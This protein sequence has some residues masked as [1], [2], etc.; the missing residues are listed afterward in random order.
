MKVLWVEDHAFAVDRLNAAAAAAS[1]RRYGI[2]LVVAT[3]LFE[4]ERRLRLER[5]DLVVTDLLLPG[6]IDEYAIVTRL[7]S[8]GR[9]R[10]AIVSD[11][12]K[13]EEVMRSLVRAGVDCA[14]TAIGKRGLALADFV[15]RPE[16]LRDFLDGLMSDTRSRAA[17]G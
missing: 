14:P 15:R 11:S 3:T 2:D 5:F 6:A 1:R 17:A 12:L 13:R 7:A 8:M 10:I 16:L 9:F 4:A